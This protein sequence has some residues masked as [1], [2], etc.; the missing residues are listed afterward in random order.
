MMMMHMMEVYPLWILAW[1]GWMGL[2]NGASVVFLR[3]TPARIVLAAFVSAFIVMETLYAANGFN[4]LLGLG[5]VLFWTPLVI[6]LYRQ[7]PAMTGNLKTWATAVLA[8]NA[9][10]LVIDYIDVARYLLGDHS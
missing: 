9:V 2:V 10:S 6:Y 1:V 3:H 7:M 8:T 5:H 4:R